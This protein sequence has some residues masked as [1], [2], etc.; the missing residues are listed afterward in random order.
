MDAATLQLS[1][2]NAAQQP[3][4]T[5]TLVTGITQENQVWIVLPASG[6]LWVAFENGDPS[7]TPQAEIW[8]QGGQTTPIAL[9]FGTYAVNGG[10]ALVYTLAYPGQPI[11]LG[12]D[13]AG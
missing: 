2:A 11:K 10:D 9:G 12:W 3:D 13:Y 7:H 5:T 4:E 1:E 6:T 8:H